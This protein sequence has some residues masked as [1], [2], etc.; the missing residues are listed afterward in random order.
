[1]TSTQW[2]VMFTIAVGVV[3]A[4]DSLKKC[5]VATN[6]T[7]DVDGVAGKVANTR[8]SSIIREY[9]IAM[10]LTGE[11]YRIG[12]LYSVAEASKRETGGCEGVEVFVNRPVTPDEMKTLPFKDQLQPSKG[13]QPASCQYTHKRLYVASKMPYFV[14]A[15]APTNSLEVDEKSWN[16]YPYIRTEYSNRYMRD[17]FH[18]VIETRHETG[19]RENVHNLNQQEL[20][21]RRVIK[22]DIANDE[23]EARDYQE[24]EDPKK[25]KS[26]KTARGPL[27]GKEWEKEQKPVMYVHK[28]YRILFKWK[29]LQNKVESVIVSSVRRVLFNF[30]RQTFCSIDAWIGMSIEDIRKLEEETKTVLKELRNKGEAKGMRID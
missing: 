1:M 19:E 21:K 23:C 17:N 10:P 7:K 22:I 9:R 8:T 29:L 20:I 11:E 4:D 25:F 5:N 27:L 3:I 24:N 13:G 26:T 12:Q 14:R 2:F 16:C 15:I 18:I 28:L 30:H 6:A